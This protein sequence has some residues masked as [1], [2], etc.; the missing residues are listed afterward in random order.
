MEKI[1]IFNNL[2]W[3]LLFMIS[4]LYSPRR[5]DVKPWWFG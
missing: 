1:V 4:G 3:L 2:E 5:F